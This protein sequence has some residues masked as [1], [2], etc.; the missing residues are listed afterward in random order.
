MPKKRPLKP[1]QLRSRDVIDLFHESAAGI[2]VSGD[3]GTG[4][5]NIMLLLMEALCREVGITLIDP[6]GDLAQDFERSCSALPRRLRD[7]VLV[8]RPSDLS[9]VVAMNP[10]YV[11]DL[12]KGRLHWRAQVTTKVSH[13]GRVVLYALGERNFDGKPVLLKWM[14]RSLGTCAEHQLTIPDSR[15][16]FDVGGEVY[17]ALTRATPEIIARTEMADL[18]EMRP[19]DR[20]ELIGSTKN[21]VL[22]YLAN[23]VVSLTLGRPSGWIDARQ[24]VRERYITIVSLERGGVLREE[25]VE[26]FANLWLSEIL[27]AVFN[28]PRHERTPHLLCADEV[29]VLAPSF[30]L[31]TRALGQIRKYQTR[32]LTGFQG[33]QL[34]PE[35]TEDRLLNALIGQC[36]ATIVLRHRNPVD[37][38]FFGELVTLPVLNPLIEKHRLTQ[39]QQ[40][41][42]GHDVAFL[43]DENETWSDADQAGGSQ[44]NAQSDTM[45]DT[46]ADNRSS[47]IGD[48]VT[49]DERTLSEAVSRARSDQTGTS[50][51]RATARGTTTTDGTS[52]SKTQTRGGGRTRKMTLVPRLRWREVTTSIEFFSTQEQ[53][54]YGARNV[55]RFGTG[56]GILY[57]AGDVPMRVQFP[58]AKGPFDRTPKFAAKEVRTL[59]REITARPEFANPEQIIGE[60]REFERRLIGHLNR[61]AIEHERPVRPQTENVS[62]DNPDDNPT[63]AI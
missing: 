46:A 15:H 48:T 14:T 42:D 20:E 56:E 61:L 54:D 13:V 17:Q 32:L 18:A 34:F 11:P 52:W 22:N 62:D 57:R 63:L 31:L 41:Q 53:V 8:I 6:H 16:F 27:F 33:T 45:T 24:L 30:D 35:R 26:I 37:A 50:S 21:R 5:S 4:K 60:R 59:R 10:L 38:K 9:N 29:P 51:S 55:T 58:L 1:K 36:G 44:S 49:R 3:S 28:L 39:W 2:A 25:D 7:R 43:T 19:R 23:P 40:Y 12:G 47:T